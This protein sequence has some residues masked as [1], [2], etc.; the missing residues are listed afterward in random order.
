MR[1]DRRGKRVK[2]YWHEEMQSPLK[3]LKSLAD[4]ENCLKPDVSFAILDADDR[5]YSDIEVANCLH[6]AR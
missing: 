3:K 5:I 1:E 4:V 2:R 6:N